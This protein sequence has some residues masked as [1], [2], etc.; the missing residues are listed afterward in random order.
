MAYARARYAVVLAA[1]REDRLEDVARLCRELGADALVCRTDVSDEQQVEAMIAAATERFGRIDV[2]VNNAGYGH[3]G[4]VH[5]FSDADMRAIF[6]VNYFGVFYGCKAAVPVMMSQGSGHIFNLSSVMGKVGMPFHGAYAATK[7][8][9]CGLSDAMRVE[10]RPHGVHVTCVCPGLTESEFSRHVRNGQKR[11][12]SRILKRLGRKPAAVVARK[13]VR[14]TGRHKPYLLFAL[15][16]RSLCL[17][18]ALCPKFTDRLMGLFYK[19]VARSM[20]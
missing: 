17:L 10:L 4:A 6:D 3:F 19:D 13:I 18:A 8:A 7:F 16:D 1:R 14:T 12:R 15:G 2:M 11:E 20:E 5:T 9:I